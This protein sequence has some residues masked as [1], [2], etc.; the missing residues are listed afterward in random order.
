MKNVRQKFFTGSI[1]RK[2][3][4]GKYLKPE[5][6]EWAWFR[7]PILRLLRDRRVNNYK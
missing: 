7:K 3:K 5:V 6:L 2:L 4:I 1:I